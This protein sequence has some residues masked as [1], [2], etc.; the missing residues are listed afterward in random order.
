MDRFGQEILKIDGILKCL[1]RT[2]SEKIVYREAKSSIITQLD[3]KYLLVPNIK[4][5]YYTEKESILLVKKHIW[6]NFFCG[7]STIK[8]VDDLHF[9][10]VFKMNL[11]NELNL[12]IETQKDTQLFVKQVRNSI[13][14]KI[15]YSSKQYIVSAASWLAGK[16]IKI[17]TLQAYYIKKQWKIWEQ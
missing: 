6:K 5:K 15:S 7:N 8:F 14:N 1:P 4:E 13:F 12:H 2:P 16:P 10:A 11:K 17:K 3:S 9:P